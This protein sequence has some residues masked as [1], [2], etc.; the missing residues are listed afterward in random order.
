MKVVRFT[1]VPNVRKSS[2][3]VRRGRG[4]RTVPLFTTASGPPVIVARESSTV[5]L[6]ISIAMVLWI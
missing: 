3:R 6:P 5:L 4:V 2:A 1:L